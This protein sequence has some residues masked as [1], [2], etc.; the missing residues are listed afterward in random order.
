MAFV[1]GMFWFTYCGNTLEEIEQVSTNQEGPT[2]ISEGVTI[3]FSDNGVPK[4]KLESPLMHRY[5]ELEESY[6]KCPIG[7]VVTFFDSIG[8][9]ESQLTANYGVY[10]STK[11]YIMVQ[12][13][14]V[15]LNNK[16]ERLDTE[17]LHIDFKKDS[18]YTH[19]KVTVTTPKGGISGTGLVSNSNFTKYKVKNINDGVLNYQKDDVNLDSDGQ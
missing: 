18:V 16:E 15:F 12:D 4:I 2:E 19:E 17:L 9:E 3:M 7:M 11:E 13:S 6:L 10:Y 5:E 1:I 8:N 14:V